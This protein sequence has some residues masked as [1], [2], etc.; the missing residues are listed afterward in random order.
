MPAKAP[1]CQD[2]PSFCDAAQP[3]RNHF[4]DRRV[5]AGC[6]RFFLKTPDVIQTG[7]VLQDRLR[8]GSEDGQGQS[9]PFQ[10]FSQM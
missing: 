1:G 3:L 7:R 2:Y 4:R 6:L 10:I 8:I 9:F 5:F